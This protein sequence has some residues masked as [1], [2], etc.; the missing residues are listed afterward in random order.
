MTKAVTNVPTT[1]F[2][3]LVKAIRYPQKRF[4]IMRHLIAT[5]L[6]AQKCA[7]IRS[8]RDGSFP[9]R[10]NDNSPIHTPYVVSHYRV[11]TLRRQTT[12]KIAYL[13]CLCMISC[14]LQKNQSIIPVSVHDYFSKG[15]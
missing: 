13:R 2:N 7:K 3:S 4:T 9:T 14:L 10:R 5:R 6:F 11:L 8:Y 12:S 1:H 15:L